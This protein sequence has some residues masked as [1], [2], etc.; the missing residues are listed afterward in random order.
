MSR[1]KQPLPDA[2]NALLITAAESRARKTTAKAARLRSGC[3]PVLALLHF[4][5]S[6][7]RKTRPRTLYLAEIVNKPLARSYVRELIAAKLVLV[8][9][10]RGCRWLSVTLDGYA[11]ASTYYRAI[12]TGCREIETED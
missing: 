7:G 4:R 1:K 8:E 5:A 2:D 3:L 10:R 11:L 12:R 6:R 9:T